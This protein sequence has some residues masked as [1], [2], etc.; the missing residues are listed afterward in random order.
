MC[1]RFGVTGM[2]FC[3]RTGDEYKLRSCLALHGCH[4]SDVS[5]FTLVSPE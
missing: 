1:S 5:P 3:S 4:V 2:L